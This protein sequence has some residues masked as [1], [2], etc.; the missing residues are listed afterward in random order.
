MSS[1]GSVR[2]SSKWCEVQSG[3]SILYV[4]GQLHAGGSERQLHYLLR[5]MNGRYQTAVVV[6]NYRF[7]DPYTARFERLGIPI[8]ALT[9]DTSPGAKLLA[10]RRVIA[11][12]RPEVVHS[13]SFYLNFIIQCAVWG[14]TAVPIGSMRSSLDVD[15]EVNGR[16]LGKLSARWPHQQIYNSARSGGAQGRLRKVFSPRQVF[17]VPNGVDLEAFRPPAFRPSDAVTI[18]GAGS[19]V[20][21]KRWDRLLAAAAGLKR[22]G[23]LFRVE[24]AGAGPLHHQLVLQAQQLEI[25]DRVTF[26][27][28]TD[29]V[30]RLFSRAAFA[31]HSSDAEGCPNAVIEAM[32]SGLAVVATDVGDVP[33]LVEDGVTGF[34]VPRYDLRMLSQRMAALITQPDLRRRMG[35]AARA[36]AEREFGL[37][38][39]VT[40]TLAAYRAAG[41]NPHALAARD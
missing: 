1:S 12:L 34:V 29:D 33:N 35:E 28:Y 21:V 25:A 24:I 36:K 13:F 41:W 8:Y 10:L 6:W 38:R 7:D 27:G 11:H 19:L 16:L 22:S 30:A 31:A 9:R 26:C 3:C 40:N 17:V 37:E 15:R 39:I 2:T 14:T 5:T 23:L 32:A 18:V 4:I 20:P